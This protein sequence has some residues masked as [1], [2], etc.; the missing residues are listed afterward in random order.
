MR[1]DAVE[2]LRYWVVREIAATEN[3]AVWRKRGD[4]MSPGAIKR[5][6]DWHREVSDLV[7]AWRDIANN[8]KRVAD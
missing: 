7:K 2:R 5:A 8:H 1:I 6:A 4:A 3:L